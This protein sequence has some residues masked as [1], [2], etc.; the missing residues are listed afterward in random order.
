VKIF[1]SGTY[2]DL[3]DYHRAACEAV[4]RKGHV[5]RDMTYFG[6]SSL[7]PADS[8]LEELKQCDVY[9]GIIGHRYGRIPDGESRSITRIEFESALCASAKNEKPKE[10]FLFLADE[11]VPIQPSFLTPDGLQ[12]QREFREYL[13]A[14]HTTKF[15]KNPDHLDRLITDTLSDFASPHASP[16]RPR[17]F[18]V[19]QEE[20]IRQEFDSSTHDRAATIET[21][22]SFVVA[23]FQNVFNL[24]HGI[25]I[26]PFFRQLKEELNE[27]IPGMSLDSQHGIV[28]R[29]GVRHVV[30]RLET[31]HTVLQ[32]ISQDQLTVLGKKIGK[33]AALDLVEHTIEAKDLI[34][35]SS[36]ALVSLWNFWDSTGGWGKLTLDT[37][38]S[39]QNPHDAWTIQV[40]NNC[41]VRAEDDKP[42]RLCAFWCGYIQGFLDTALKRLTEIIFTLE[43]SERSEVT[44][45]EY[46]RVEKVEH[47][48]DEKG[49]DLFVVTFRS[50]RYSD[51]L[52]HLRLSQE[53]LGKGDYKY[54]VLFA[55][56]AITDARSTF[57]DK[58]FDE[59]VKESRF[60]QT[61]VEQIYTRTEGSPDR[62]SAKR[63]FDAA[64][65]IIQGL[66]NASIEFE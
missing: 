62:E 23:K 54:C 42:H 53:R 8:S 11:S 59:W 47:S 45:P 39:G 9:I 32:C 19:D 41:F 43:P 50:E 26:H 35:R 46:H 52:R 21:F 3:E 12:K 37:A 2:E 1:I 38:R 31:L 30:L 33:S 17:I 65:L 13:K 20:L 27:K 29:G 63:K 15:F 66:A 34:P 7:R 14:N 40:T 49:A 64:N 44:L 48:T 60:D 4:T 57:G 55:H 22:M 10:V 5:P 58:K 36:A 56:D 18:D 61:I 25:D 24:K 28:K 16:K 51:A 6:A